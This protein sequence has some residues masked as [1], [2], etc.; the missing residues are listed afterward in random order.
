MKFENIKEIIAFILKK[1]DSGGNP[2]DVVKKFNLKPDEYDD[3]LK[4]MVI[5]K[6]IECDEIYMNQTPNLDYAFITNKG[7][8]LIDKY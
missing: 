4:T 6:Y 7:Y 1:I 5:D 2:D 3:I 8:R